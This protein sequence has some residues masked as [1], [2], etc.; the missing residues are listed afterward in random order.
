MRGTENWD[1]PFSFLAPPVWITDFWQQALM[2]G[3][4]L[5]LTGSAFDLLQFLEVSFVDWVHLSESKLTILYFGDWQLR[6]CKD[7]ETK[8]HTHTQTRTRVNTHNVPLRFGMAMLCRHN[9]VA[10]HTSGQWHF[11]S[12]GRTERTGCSNTTE[13]VNGEQDVCM[14]LNPCTPNKSTSL[15]SSVPSVMRYCLMSWCILGLHTKTSIKNA[16]EPTLALTKQAASTTLGPGHQ[17]VFKNLL[18]KLI[19]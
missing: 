16:N 12:P 10:P 9:P 5:F 6:T 13:L 14:T 4:N 15:S 2:S 7:K 11:Y 19:N 17:W 18:I 3:A 1:S 8:G